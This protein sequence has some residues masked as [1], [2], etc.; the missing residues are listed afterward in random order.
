MTVMEGVHACLF[1]QVVA[2]GE[3]HVLLATV[4]QL[5]IQEPARTISHSIKTTMTTYSASGRPELQEGLVA[6][7]TYASALVRGPV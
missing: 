7:S 6:Y 1:P 5:S 4:G 3:A 2:A